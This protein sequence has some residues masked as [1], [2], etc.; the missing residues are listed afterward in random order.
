MFFSA[1]ELVPNDP[2]SLYR[3]CQAYEGLQKYEEAYKDALMIMKNDPKNKSVGEILVRLSPIIQERVREE[4]ESIV[5][6]VIVSILVSDSE[7]K[8]D[9]KP[10]HA[11]VFT[12]V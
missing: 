2:K 6:H 1:L 8:L 9:S 4:S 7:A 3:R 12:G 11:N 5:N 10:S